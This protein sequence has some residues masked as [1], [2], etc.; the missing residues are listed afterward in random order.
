MMRTQ[1]SQ[2]A[3]TKKWNE[4][5]IN[6]RTANIERQTIRIFNVGRSFFAPN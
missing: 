2:A 6:I 5:K 1:A 4:I 3:A